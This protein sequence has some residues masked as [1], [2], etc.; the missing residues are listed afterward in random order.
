MT[1][2]TPTTVSW[3]FAAVSWAGVFATVVHQIRAA[4]REKQFKQ[5][6]QAVE[7]LAQ[8]KGLQG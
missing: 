2:I 5:A 7:H 3:F 4:A 8:K 6:E 1:H